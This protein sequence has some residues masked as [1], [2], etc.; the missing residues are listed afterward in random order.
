MP[1]L[2]YIV[3]KPLTSFKRTPLTASF[4]LFRFF[5][6]YFP[7]FFLL[8]YS[9]FMGKVGDRKTQSGLLERIFFSPV[10]DTLELR[11]K[12]LHHFFPLLNPRSHP[13][14]CHNFESGPLNKQSNVSSK[15]PECLFASSRASPLHLLC[16]LG[17]SSC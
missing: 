2:S 6:S 8:F 10:L 12:F 11:L 9:N 1:R 13:A 3:V 7:V 5:N 17:S 16:F 14:H 4:F 15:S